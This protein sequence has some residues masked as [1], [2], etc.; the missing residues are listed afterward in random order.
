ME[1]NQLT[2]V[3]YVLDGKMSRFTVQAFASGFLSGFGHNP[4]I[5]IRD[6]SGVVQLSPDSL[7]ASLNIRIAAASLSVQG[8]VSDKDRR[9]I[10]RAMRDQ[11]LEAAQFPE[12]TFGSTQVALTKTSEGSFTANITGDLSLHGVTRSHSF[13]AQV[14]I[15]G[16]ML[17]SFGQF[18][19][20]QTD[21]NIK[22]FSAAG[23]A[24]KVKDELKFS[25]DMVARKQ[26]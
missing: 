23:G 4:T 22:L 1:T 10:E 21:Y 6:L 13:V 5:A 7:D 8:N 26:A 18:S 16:D 12:I 19:L 9:D 24:L 20:M 25:F 17:R 15:T 3:Q 2:R 14:S 11:V